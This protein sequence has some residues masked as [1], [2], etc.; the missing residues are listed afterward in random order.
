MSPGRGQQPDEGSE[1]MR[2]AEKDVDLPLFDLEVILVATDDFAE[3]KKVGAG[4]FGPV[5]MVKTTE[6]TE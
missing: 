5:Y 6:A 4:G 3:H 1:G 2:Y